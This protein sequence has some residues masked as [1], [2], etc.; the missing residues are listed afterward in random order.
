M[1]LWYMLSNHFI[2]LDPIQLKQS[3]PMPV[4][5]ASEEMQQT[6]L[7]GVRR[8]SK[9]PVDDAVCSSWLVAELDRSGSLHST[10]QSFDS[11]EVSIVVLSSN[12]VFVQG[13][14][15]PNMRGSKPLLRNKS[16]SLR[17]RR[18]LRFH[19]HCCREYRFL[20]VEAPR[21]N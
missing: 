6:A 19:R 11:N 13:C 17:E 14:E 1:R 12:H 16:S 21:P 15:E 20:R 4:L 8:W 5:P 2:H 9:G 10:T 18:E 7:V 3:V